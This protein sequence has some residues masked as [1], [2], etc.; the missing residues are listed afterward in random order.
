MRIGQV[1]KKSRPDRV[2][3]LW[4]TAREREGEEKL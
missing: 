2:A 1:T 4:P 3:N